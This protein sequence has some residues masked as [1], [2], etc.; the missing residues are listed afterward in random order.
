MKQTRKI[1]QVNNGK[2]KTLID[3][4]KNLLTAD[5]VLSIFATWAS[6][7]YAQGGYRFPG[8]AGP[9][10]RWHGWPFAYMGCSLEGATQCMMNRWVLA[11]NFLAWMAIFSFVLLMGFGILL[12]LQRLTTFIRKPV[13]ITDLEPAMEV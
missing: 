12:G 9:V 8:Q 10:L 4:V 1:R 2:D 13:S 11:Q 3:Q 5:F 7:F 6:M